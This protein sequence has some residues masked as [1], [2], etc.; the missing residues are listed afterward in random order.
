MNKIFKLFGLALLACTFT[1]A[2]CGGDD[3]VTPGPDPDPNGGNGGGNDQPSSTIAKGNVT[4]TGL[5]FNGDGTVEFR[6]STGEDGETY[7]PV[8]NGNLVFYDITMENNIVTLSSG[9]PN[10]GWDRIK[11]LSANTTIDATTQYWGSEGD[12][13]LQS[14]QGSNQ[15]VGLKFKLGD[16]IHYGWAS[17][18]HNG[19]S[20]TWNE[21]YYNTTPNQAIKAGQ[22]Q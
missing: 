7:Q 3:P 4:S 5:D 1:L 14:N 18:T 10:E 13:S 6:F 22:K 21:I 20:A 16:G 8:T 19:S 12:A 9:Y 2:S 11:N 17:A 15:I